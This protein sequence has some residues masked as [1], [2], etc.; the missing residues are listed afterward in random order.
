MRKKGKIMEIVKD[1]WAALAASGW[2][3]AS[4]A[5]ALGMVLSA[6]STVHAATERQASAATAKSNIVALEHQPA[7]KALIRAT[8]KF[9]HIST[10]GGRTWNEQA[11]PAAAK[12]KVGNV[13][14]SAR[15]PNLLF[16]SGTEFGV[17]RSRDRGKTWNAANKGLPGQ[18]VTAL[19]THSDQAETVY[20]YIPGKGIFRSQDAGAEWR[21]M[22]RGPRSGISE[23][24][25]SSMPG[26]MESGWL[27][28][29]TPDGV[30]RSM[31]CFCG[32]H[33][34][35]ETKGSYHA[36][37]YDPAQPER[38]YAASH[39]GLLVSIDGGEQWKPIS[40]PPSKASDL[41]VSP[42]GILYA[43]G[44]KQI[45]RSKDQGKTWE[46]VDA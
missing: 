36:V 21:L 9:L 13:A 28:A 34:A 25:H 26:S 31:D 8:P 46:K 23:F 16:M 41:M 24:V 33:R 7:A 18:K 29:A 32:W 12:G 45:Y 15:D 10:D 37:T 11:L 35:G 40:A 27:F 14:A 20:V 4:A 19:T 6:H 5:I 42:D 1:P 43:A 30:W 3:R 17:L 39:N 38:V 44:Q 2:R 22:D